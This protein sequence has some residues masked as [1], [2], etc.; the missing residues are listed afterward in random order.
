MKIHMCLHATFSVI[1]A[2]VVGRI[3]NYQRAV[4]AVR[5]MR[6]SQVAGFACEGMIALP[7]K[8]LTGTYL[9]ILSAMQAAESQNH[10][11]LTSTDSD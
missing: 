10:G 1:I 8:A 11:S 4:R 3:I 7:Q 6:K 5:K 2:C 9:V